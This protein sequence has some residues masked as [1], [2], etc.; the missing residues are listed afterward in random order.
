MLKIKQEVDKSPCPHEAYGLLWV[1][2][3]ETMITINNLYSE[4]NSDVINPKE[5][6][7]RS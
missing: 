7:K 4:L 6:L 3:T 2:R 5:E 1:Q